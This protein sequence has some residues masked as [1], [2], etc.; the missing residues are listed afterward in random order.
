MLVPSLDRMIVKLC[1]T[2][3]L[4]KR[5]TEIFQQLHV[6]QGEEEQAASSLAKQMYLQ[7][8]PLHQPTLY[9]KTQEEKV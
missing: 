3:A 5:A 4:R 6:S 9:P 8:E 7:E 2:K 1:L